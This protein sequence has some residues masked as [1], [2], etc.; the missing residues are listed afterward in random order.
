M[1]VL[2]LSG[3]ASVLNQNSPAGQRTE[4]YRKICGELEVLLCQR[5]V[6]SFVSGFWRGYKLM[7]QKRF[8]VVTAQSPE[9]WFLAWSLSKIFGT[10]WQMQIH[11]DIFSR[12]FAKESWKNKIRVNLAKFLATRANG[13][14]VVSERIKN[15]LTSNL[16]IPESKIQTSPIFVDIEKIKNSPA[17]TDLRQKYPGK[18]IVLMASR[19][20]REKSI[21]FAVDVLSSLIRANRRIVLVIAGEGS[22]RK[23][24]E[25]RIVNYGLGDNIVI[26]NWNNDLISYYKS[27]DLFLLTSN[28]EGYGLALLEAA[29]SGAKIISSDVGI[30]PELLDRENIFRVGDKNDLTLKLELA[31]DGK[32]SQPKPILPQTKE[33]YLRLYKEYL[34]RCLKK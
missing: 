33:N 23:N 16:S 14:R 17:R 28:Y 5:S 29:A 12:H 7:R 10:P 1:R 11:T 20:S 18:F 22:E 4:E 15:S 24:L 21:G 8:D 6:S 26:E 30:A 31:I 27:C 9:H 3:D 32:I 19:L 2:M 13:I 25:L 34:E